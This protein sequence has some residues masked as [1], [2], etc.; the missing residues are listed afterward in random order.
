M[1][2]ILAGL[3][4]TVAM[5]GTAAAASNY[6]VNVSAAPAKVSAKGS[7]TI[8]VEPT[9]GFKMNLEYPTKV[10]LKAPDGVTLEKSKLSA[11][12]AS[13]LD[14]TGAVFNVAFTA[15]EPGKKTVTGE[16]RFAVCTDNECLPKTEAVSFV[17]DAQ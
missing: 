16:L 4:V 9:D 6:K 1:K 2:K 7:A 13:K 5:I 17:V 14:K 15:S 11:K 10:T 12:D 3:L 8:S